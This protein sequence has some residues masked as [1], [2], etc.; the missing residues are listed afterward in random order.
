[1]TRRQANKIILSAINLVNDGPEYVISLKEISSELMIDIDRIQEAREMLPKK[2][3]LY[4]QL[5][6]AIEYKLTNQISKK[7]VRHNYALEI[8]KTDFNTDVVVIPNDNTMVTGRQIWLNYT[9]SLREILKQTNVPG[10]GRE[11]C[12]AALEVIDEPDN[13]KGYVIIWATHNDGDPV[14][15]SRLE[16]KPGFKPVSEY[17]LDLV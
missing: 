11:A 4:F 7:R 2:S 17:G 5:L 12:E 9:K 15:L 1:M 10:A 3:R 8:Y 14:E 13:L 6:T 16:L